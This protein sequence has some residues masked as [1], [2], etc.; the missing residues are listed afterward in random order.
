MSR[1]PYQTWP[2]L[3]VIADKPKWV[4]WRD[5]ALTLMMWL[6]FAIMLET[7][8]E[9]FFGRFMER[10]GFGDFHTDANWGVFFEKLRPFITMTL[11]LVTI[12]A[13]AGVATIQRRRRAL[14]LD[15]PPILPAV[16]QA[17]RAGMD[18]AALLAART[19]SNV[20]VHVDAHG[21]HRIEAR[22]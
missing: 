8:F 3:I 13:V 22:V 4:W 1:R 6:L 14:L 12:L 5:F 7:E 9:L 18:E 20:V 15:S 17:R 16:D 10:L 19:M 11:V 21:V 2:P